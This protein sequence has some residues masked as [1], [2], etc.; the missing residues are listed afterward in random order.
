[1]QS[2]FKSL[3]LPENEELLKEIQSGIDERFLELKKLSKK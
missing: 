1:M 3:L 2:R